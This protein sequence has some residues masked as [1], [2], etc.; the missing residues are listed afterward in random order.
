MFVHLSHIL[1]PDGPHWPSS[2]TLSYD[3]HSVLGEDGDSNDYISH[4]PNHFGT[5]MDAPRHFVPDGVTFAELPA[6]RFNF[7]GDEILLLDIPEKGAPKSIVTIEDMEPYLEDFEG[8]RM[9][10]IRTGFERYRTENPE[11]YMSEGPCLDPDLCKWLATETRVQCVGFDWISV[12]A[13]WNDLGTEAHRQ[14]LGYYRDNFI[15]AIEDLSLEP[16][17]DA[18][19]DFITL[20]PLRIKGIDSSQVSVTAFLNDFDLFD[21]GDDHDDDLGEAPEEAS[22]D[23]VVDTQDAPEPAAEDEP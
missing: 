5:H 8:I 20:G 11:V 23:R 4:L 3:H 7:D 15:T 17:G 19:I 16:V 6:E 13:P 14:L 12:G 10:L 9:L 18:W 2:P 21:D 1:D 22:F